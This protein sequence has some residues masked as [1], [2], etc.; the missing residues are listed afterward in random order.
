MYRKQDRVEQGLT[1]ALEDAG[2]QPAGVVPEPDAQRCR[3]RRARIVRGPQE[4]YQRPASLRKQVQSPERMESGVRP[5]RV[6]NP[7]QHGAELSAAQALFQC[8]VTFPRRIRANENVVG[9]VEAC[10]GQRG[11]VR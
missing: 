6:R 11:G 5:L 2:R 9:R 7:S 4:E 8:P 1:A 3:G 10:L